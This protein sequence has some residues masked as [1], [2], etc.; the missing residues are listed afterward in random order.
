M[1]WTLCT[2]RMPEQRQ[3]C[4]VACYEWS[5]F[6]DR[7]DSVIKYRIL[8]YLPDAGIWNIKEPLRV[9]AW[10]PIP[11]F[12]EKADTDTPVSLPYPHKHEE[13]LCMPESEEQNSDEKNSDV[14]DEESLNFFRE[15]TMKLKKMTAHLRE[16]TEQ[17]KNGGVS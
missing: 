3:R 13:R 11:E 9:L 16:L 8:E 5:M 17:R 1:E 12:T 14:W 7:F 4:V 10:I 6:D 15:S 2:E